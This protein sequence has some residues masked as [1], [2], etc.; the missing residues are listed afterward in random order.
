MSD[1]RLVLKFEDDS[2]S[3]ASGFETGFLYKEMSD[4]G[5]IED[6]YIHRTN[7]SMIEK[8]CEHFKYEYSITP[9][10]SDW[11]LLNAKPNQLSQIIYN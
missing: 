2:P 1:Y 3:F 11:C 8:V 5:E 9:L 7:V 6:K 4:G 10:D